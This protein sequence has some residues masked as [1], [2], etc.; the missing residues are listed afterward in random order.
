MRLIQG[1]RL[2]FRE[3]RVLPGTERQYDPEEW[4]EALVVIKAGPIEL[5]TRHGVRCTFVSGNV[6]FLSGLGLRCMSNPGPRSAVLLAVS[7]R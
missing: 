2:R 4:R 5:E 1:H 3:V 7:R 6:L